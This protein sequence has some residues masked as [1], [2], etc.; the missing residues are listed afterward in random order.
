MIVTYKNT[1][2]KFCSYLDLLW[3]RSAPPSAAG[4]WG[5]IAA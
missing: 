3:L 1:I 2:A 4:V 5:S